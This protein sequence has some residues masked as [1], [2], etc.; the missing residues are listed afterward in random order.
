[1]EIVEKLIQLP[2]TDPPLEGM[3]KIPQAARG[4]VLFAHGSGSSRFS[5]RN[6]FVADV[7]NQSGL[8]TVLIDLLTAEE[9]AIYQT[10]F[11]IELLSQ[12][13]AAVVVWLAKLPESCMLSFGLFGASTGA[14]AAM[15][16]AARLS[17]QI[18][19]VVSRGGRP[20]LAMK[21]L[22]K[23]KAPTL[24]IV[25]GSDTDV[26]ELNRA[27]F[28]KLHCPKAFKVIENATHLFE[29]TG[30]LEA[31]ASSAND[32]FLEQLKPLYR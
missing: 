8:A 12:R 21:V 25:G 3:L 10:R 2:F 7:L 9:D 24:L 30:A 11:D 16:V 28:E 1:M 15:M 23:I 22:D 6:N 14:A 13:L 20:D 26:L 18:Q 4:L 17:S 5:P 19:A 27:A 31:V 32:W 29:E